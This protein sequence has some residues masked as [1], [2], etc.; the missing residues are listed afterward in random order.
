L[1]ERDQEERRRKGKRQ[2]RRKK[3]GEKIGVKELQK[4]IIG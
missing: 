2:Q 3:G 1:K 4:I